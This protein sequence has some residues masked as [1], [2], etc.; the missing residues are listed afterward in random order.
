MRFTTPTGTPVNGAL[1]AFG[2][3]PLRWLPGAYVQFLRIDGTE[4]TDP[5]QGQKELSGTL[6][7]VLSRLDELL[8]INIS[9]TMDLTTGPR[10]VQRSDY[11]LAALQQFARNAVMHRTYE[12]TNTPARI[13]WFSDRIEILS[14][15][16]LYGQ[17]NPENFGEGATDYRN[18]LVAE[19]MKVLG[20]VQRFGLGI[21]LARQV[22]A[23]N[24]NRPP[25]FD[26]RPESVLVMLRRVG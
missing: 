7:E 24:G 10:E 19:A 8:A 6:H 23:R 21:P 1:L 4:L 17:V 25:E 11:P 14:P 2:R 26:L 16:G 5:I 22:L 3:D 12:G 20:Y 15:G 18:P 9:T 13:S